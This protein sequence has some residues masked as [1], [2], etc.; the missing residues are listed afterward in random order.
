MAMVLWIIVLVV[1]AIAEA[2]TTA[3]VSIWFCV[4]AV[5]AA[6]AAGLG[7]PVFFQLLVFVVVSI[8]T[9]LVSKPIANKLLPN[10]LIPTN[11]E[12]DIGKHAIVVEDINEENGT[13]RVRLGD[14]DWGA[15][16][17][18][19]STAV[20]GTTVEVVEKGAAMLKVRRIN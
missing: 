15:R 10:R 2:V 1:A 4:G 5:A 7:A 16:L 18:D 14:V 11:G 12:D 17:I 9:L 6:V 3:L 8:L 19:G 20:V 13:G